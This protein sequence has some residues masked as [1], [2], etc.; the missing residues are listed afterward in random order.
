M[1]RL[2]KRSVIC[3]CLAALLLAGAGLFVFR[4]FRDGADWVVFYGNRSVYENGV[5]KSGSIRDRNGLLLSENKDGQVIYNDDAEI[6]K[7]TVH[8]VGDAEGNVATS[9]MYAYRDR[10]IGYHPLTGTYKAAGKMDDLDLTLD[11]NLCRVAYEQL[12]PYKAG[13]VGV[14]NYETGEI[15]CMVSTPTFDPMDYDPQNPE[16]G[17]YI[18]RFLSSRFPPGSI[19]KTV[20]AGAAL[21]NLPDW[22]SFHY[23]CDGVRLVGNE[24]LYCFYPHGEVDI[25][26]AMA[27]SCNGAFSLL[28]D[29]MGAGNLAAYTKKVGLETSYDMDGIRSIAG[30]FNFPD[31]NPFNL[32]WAGV[33]QYMDQVNPCSMMVYMGALA[34]GGKAPAPRLLKKRL[35]LSPKMDTLLAPDVADQVAGMM[36]AAVQDGYGESRFPGLDIYAKTGTA[37]QKDKDPYGW[38]VGF[39]RNPEA[40]YAFVVCLE[41]SGEALYTAAPVA[42]AVLQ[43]ACG[44]R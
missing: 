43:A 17:Q 44:N 13:C 30:A 14:Y 33:G 29:Q 22:E 40:P 9:A 36:K 16:E 19:F 21:E 39:L 3:L 23:A 24:K 18:N 26:G 31:D 41:D 25:K 11:A 42:N 4:F 32:G 2:E 15:L 34:H 27:T 7:A 8:A 28:A 20:T 5:L 38:F 1:K 12:A 6:R 35:D 37:E 10:L